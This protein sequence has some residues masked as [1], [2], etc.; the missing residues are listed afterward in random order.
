ML[1][2]PVPELRRLAADG[3]RERERSGPVVVPT[4]PSLS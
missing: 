3:L 1:G 2:V 4:A